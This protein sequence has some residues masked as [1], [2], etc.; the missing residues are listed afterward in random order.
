[1]EAFLGQ[2][3]CESLCPNHCISSVC[4]CL[5]VSPF[6]V[7]AA[8]ARAAEAAR[9]AGGR[10]QM[11]RTK[12]S[13]APSSDSCFNSMVRTKESL[14]AVLLCQWRRRNLTMTTMMMMMIQ[15][16]ESLITQDTQ[17]LAASG[18]RR[19]PEK[20]GKNS[21]TER[22]RRSHRFGHRRLIGRRR[23]IDAARDAAG[24]AGAE[25]RCAGCEQSDD[26]PAIGRRSFFSFSRHQPI[27][28]R[29]A[30]AQPVSSVASKNKKLDHRLCV[31]FFTFSFFFRLFVVFFS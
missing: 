16:D 29:F 7:R 19:R 2:S 20:P 13:V 5:C 14:G 1:M 26:R 24:D 31:S 15:R 11:R 22:P 12:G 18:G 25:N 21:V 3:L 9:L 4:L 28:L 27:K 8:R 17:L 10:M 23:R 30:V 6:S